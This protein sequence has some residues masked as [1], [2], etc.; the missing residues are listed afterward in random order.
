M[1][2]A[3][4]VLNFVYVNADKQERHSRNRIKRSA[5]RSP[6]TELMSSHSSDGC[7]D[8]IDMP[9]RHNSTCVLR[10]HDLRCDPDAERAEPANRR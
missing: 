2:P 10:S 9:K 8:I 7:G 1:Q 5:L 6:N 3:N 4:R